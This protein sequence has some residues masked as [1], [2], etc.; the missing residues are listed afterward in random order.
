MGAVRS[1]HP[2]CG[3]G[4]RFCACIMILRRRDM[5]SRLRREKTAMAVRLRFFLMYFH[6][7]Y[8][9][10]VGVFKR[11]LDIRKLCILNFENKIRLRGH[12]YAS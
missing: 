9:I 11:F 1:F 10:D 3:E 12:E 2:A 7:A 6:D 8:D 4:C 5:W